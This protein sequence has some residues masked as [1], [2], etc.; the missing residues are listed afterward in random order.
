MSGSRSVPTGCRQTSNEGAAETPARP[1]IPADTPTDTTAAPIHLTIRWSISPSLPRE[2]SCA[3]SARRAFST[4][5]AT[6]RGG[7]ATCGEV[8]VVE[9]VE[10]PGPPL[11]CAPAPRR[12]GRV[13]RRILV[14]R[15]EI[16]S[17]L[18]SRRPVTSL[19]PKALATTAS[20]SPKPHKN[21]R[22][23]PFPSAERPWWWWKSPEW[24]A[25]TTSEWRSQS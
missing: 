11:R 9:G 23:T 12:A 24:S 19:C 18:R 21:C 4:N 16:V 14:R 6:V 15:N 8:A 7:C 2:L 1:I 13:A 17:P 5:G 25:P 22:T 10:H 3:A 20:P